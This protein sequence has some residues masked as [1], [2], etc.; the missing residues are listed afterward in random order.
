[1]RPRGFLSKQDLPVLEDY[2]RRYG[3]AQLAPLD[4]PNDTDRR[5]DVAAIV[6]LVRADDKR[7]SRN[8]R[9]AQ[10]DKFRQRRRDFLGAFRKLR[11]PRGLLHQIDVR[12]IFE[13]IRMAFFSASLPAMF[14]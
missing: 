10:V 1:M 11:V 7:T 6:R 9:H 14:L 13:L 12:G 8:E 5:A 3:F 2:S 4:D